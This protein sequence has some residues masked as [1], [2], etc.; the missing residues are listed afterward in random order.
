[1]PAIRRLPRWGAVVAGVAVLAALPW[2]V[3]RLPAGSNTMT[4]PALLARIAASTSQGYSGLAESTGGLALPVTSQFNSIADLLGG[5][6][7]LRVWWRAASDFRVDQ[8]DV[9]GETDTVQ[10]AAGMWSWDY[11]ANVAT[12][13][14]DVAQAKVRLPRAADLL[15]PEVGRR[16]LSQAQPAE[17]SRLGSERVAGQD[18]MGVQL[19][20][21]SPATSIGRVDV[22]ADKA[23]GLPLRVAVYGRSGGAVLTTK[24][25]DVS[26]SRPDAARTAFTPPPEARV[27]RQGRLDIAAAIDRFGGDQPPSQV[28]GLARNNEMP[29]IGA[30]GIYGRGVTEL[31]AVPL[32]E[33]VAASLRD[34]LA[35]TPGVA[36]TPDGGFVISV[37]PL[38]LL[39]AE[40]SSTGA[41]WL[42]TGTV[43]SE[44]LRTAEAQLPPA[45][46][47]R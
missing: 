11:E 35:S 29:A 31:A 20:P 12:R 4:A 3:S 26:T 18:A 21:S 28:A 37:G 15:P 47:F 46:G 7:Q 8:I 10:D 27:R 45:E 40:P 36:E 34:Q 17:L 13:S 30:V 44:T 19:H 9:T 2:A 22:W 14:D 41:A 1:V 43:T 5:Q 25:L 32:P 38:S 6:T 39:I 24:F 42:L 23:S 33:D 16:L